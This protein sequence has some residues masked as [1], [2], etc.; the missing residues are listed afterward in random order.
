MG[1]LSFLLHLHLAIHTPAPK[2]EKL[3]MLCQAMGH[4][5]VTVYASNIFGNGAT[6]MPKD[7]ATGNN[8]NFWYAI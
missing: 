7:F 3:P 6:S 1:L 5:N 2:V 8:I 4:V